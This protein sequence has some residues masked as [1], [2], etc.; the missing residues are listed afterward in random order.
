MRNSEHILRKDIKDGTARQERKR[1]TT[2]GGLVRKRVGVRE[3]G[4]RDRVRWRQIIFCSD[5]YINQA[6]DCGKQNTR[7]QKKQF[8]EKKLVFCN[9]LGKI[10]KDS[11]QTTTVK[12]VSGTLIIVLALEVL[13]RT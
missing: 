11:R 3:E 12:C 1:K 10:I 6:K 7:T 13:S 2:E 4:V 8:L 9:I 5:P